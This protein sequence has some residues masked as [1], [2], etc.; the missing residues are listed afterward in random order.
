MPFLE[1]RSIGMK[2]RAERGGLFRRAIAPRN[3]SRVSCNSR[4]SSNKSAGG[5]VRMSFTAPASRSNGILGTLNGIPQGAIGSVQ[6][7]RIAETDGLL[8]IALV[9]VEIRMEPRLNS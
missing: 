1:I 3:S 8:R 5:D 6:H 4:I 7:G 9:L 2:F